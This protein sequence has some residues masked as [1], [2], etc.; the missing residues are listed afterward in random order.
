MLAKAVSDCFNLFWKTNKP[1]RKLKN[2]KKHN[3]EDDP[4]ESLYVMW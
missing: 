2:R 3:T 4:K 1:N